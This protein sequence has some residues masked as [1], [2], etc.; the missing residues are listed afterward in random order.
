[1]TTNGTCNVGVPLAPT[2]SALYLVMDPSRVMHGAF[3]PMGAATALSLSLTDPVF[4]R[5]FAAF[6]FLPGQP[7]DCTAA[8]TPFTTPLIDFALAADVQPQIAA[9]LAV[10]AAPDADAG[11]PSPLELQAALRLDAGVYKHV[12]DFLVNKELPNI[13]A[14]MFFVNRAPDT[15][16]D[17]DPPLGGQPTVQAAL[18]S[19]ILAAYNG[20]PSLQTY[21]VVLDDDAHDEASPTGGLTFFQNVQADSAAGGPDAGRHADEQ[22]AGRPD[23]GGELLQ[24]RHPARYVRLRLRAAAEH[25]PV[26]GRGGVRHPGASRQTIVPASAGCSAATQNTIDGWN[27]DSGR[28]R[29]CGSS[30]NNLRQGVLASSGAALMSGQPAPD[31]PVTATILCSGSAPVSDAGPSEASAETDSSVGTGSS[32]GCQTARWRAVTTGAGELD[33]GRRTPPSLPKAASRQSGAQ[34]SVGLAAYCKK[35]LRPPGRQRL[36]MTPWL[37]RSKSL[38]IS[39]LAALASWRFCLLSAFLRPRASG[40]SSSSSVFGQSPRRRRESP[41]SARSFPAVWHRAQ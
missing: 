21:F 7:A 38:G 4:K 14:A 17:C 36:P 22:H 32:P 31:I 15:T 37:T 16:N 13:A 29:I 25:G 18:E 11:T 41:R 40:L 39:H 12:I 20:T 9:K 23:G 2:Q 6:T 27:V 1:M 8:T 28:L 10:P 34:R 30:C 26:D 3:G 19:E 24:G 35:R 5:T 33:D